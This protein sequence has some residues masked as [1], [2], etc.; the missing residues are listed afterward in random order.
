MSHLCRTVLSEG[1]RRVSRFGN[2]KDHVAI[3]V[4][5]PAM[6]GNV[7]KAGRKAQLGMVSVI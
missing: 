5:G 4:R 7:S 3:S 6:N 2:S 1:L